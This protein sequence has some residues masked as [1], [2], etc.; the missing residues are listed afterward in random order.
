[1]H[2]AKGAG[3]QAKNKR[4]F[5]ELYADHVR[6]ESKVGVD[7][8]WER[9]DD[10]RASRIAVYR[11]GAITDDPETLADLRAWVVETMARFFGVLAGPAE[12]A[13]AEAETSAD[14]E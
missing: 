2:V 12:H 10:K 7:L 1:M 11:P 9:L 8:S 13:L 14:R 6:L 5:D 3:D 4:V